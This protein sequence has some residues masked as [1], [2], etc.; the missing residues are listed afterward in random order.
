MNYWNSGAK[1]GFQQGLDSVD[2]FNS[3]I[4]SAPHS[5]VSF[6]LLT[7]LEETLIKRGW[8]PWT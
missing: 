6:V 5:K 1:E 3:P 8:E 7:C 4:V 2:Y